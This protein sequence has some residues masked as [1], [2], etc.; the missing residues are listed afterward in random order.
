ML[1]PY[2]SVEVVQ[3]TLILVPGVSDGLILACALLAPTAPGTGQGHPGGMSFTSFAHR[4]MGRGAG[5]VT[6]HIITN[7]QVHMSD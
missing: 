7:S 5:W 3:S 1:G 6:V 4:S 2:S